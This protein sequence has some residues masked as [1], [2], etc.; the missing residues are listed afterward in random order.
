[1]VER[2]LF[3]LVDTLF[4]AVVDFNFLEFEVYSSGRE[5]LCGDFDAVG[6]PIA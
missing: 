3:F 2:S 4:K 1:M 5:L 6:F